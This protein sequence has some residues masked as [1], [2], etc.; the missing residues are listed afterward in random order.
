MSQVIYSNLIFDFDGVL[1]DSNEIRT[2][3]FVNLFQ[4]RYQEYMEEFSKFLYKNPGMSRYEKIKHFYLRYL[5]IKIS[6][7][8]L[9]LESDR[10]SNLVKEKVISA[11]PIDGS[12]EFL[13]KYRSKF[14][15]ALVSASDGSELK[16]IC[17]RRYI[18]HFFVDVLGSPVKK[19]ENISIV[20]EK[21]EWV[22]DN[23]IY[24]G[25][26]LHDFEASRKAGVPFLGFGCNFK[27]FGQF[28]KNFYELSVLADNW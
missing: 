17:K 14:N 6:P 28:V 18:S 4:D 2:K 10:Y 24:I 15:F 16:D 11:K 5:K 23:S 8:Q 21:F 20:L 27:E 1:V 19:S 7:N 13:E 12:S 3:G 26:S 25:D 22:R 9:G